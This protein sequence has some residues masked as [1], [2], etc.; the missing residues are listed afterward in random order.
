MLS[1]EQWNDYQVDGFM[2]LGKVLQ[3]A[4]LDALKRRADDLASG[5]L[6]NPDIQFQMDTGGPYE[7]LPSAVSEIGKDTHLY[8]KI[9]GLESDD[10][11]APLVKHP[12]FLAICAQ[13][14][15]RHAPVSIFRAMV[16][17][18]PAG[19]GT[20][21]PWHQDGGDVWAL[22][23][24]PLV[25]IW[26]ALD[27]AT[28]ENGCVE[29]IPGS[30]RLGLLRSYGSTVLPEDVARYCP[31]E[32][33]LPLEVPAGHAVLMHNWLIHRSGVNPT[34]GPRRA[35]TAC[36]VD[37]R[38][39]SALTGNHFPLIAGALPE[40]YPYLRQL[41]GDCATLRESIGTA[42]VYAR[43]LE[44][45]IARMRGTGKAQG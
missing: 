33:V 29:V 26:V 5:L 32:K 23:R 38:T 41:R 9:Q 14:Y 40:T 39:Q 18:K 16:M 30:H 28:R 44:D 43:S 4:E 6:G 45:E 31:P 21:L 11:F 17:N 15:G 19:Q 3:D 12:L 37:G 8:R 2:R 1:N 27:P 34:S 24:D 20:V 36:Y 22:D 25:T 13:Q 7:E 35:F 42:T 10:H